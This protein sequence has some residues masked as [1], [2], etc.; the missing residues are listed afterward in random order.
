[1]KPTAWS[2]D[3]NTILL[4]NGEKIIVNSIP[5]SP[6]T[7]RSFRN[8]VTV[9]D[10]L[11][12]SSVSEATATF[13]IALVPSPKLVSEEIKPVVEINRLITPIP[14]GPNKRAITFERTIDI[15]T[16]KT[17]TPP[18]MDVALKI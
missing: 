7:H 16:L 2:L 4:S 11:A 9:R 10:I 14:A 6:V 3:P 5:N 18:K 1:M 12:L 13:F 8:T 17:C 15:I